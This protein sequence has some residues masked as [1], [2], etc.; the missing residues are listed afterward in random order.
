MN[1]FKFGDCQSAGRNECLSRSL[2]SLENHGTHL[3]YR[4]AMPNDRIDTLRGFQ[5]VFLWSDGAII[6]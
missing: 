5:N 3:S 4:M 1:T 2:F 6:R